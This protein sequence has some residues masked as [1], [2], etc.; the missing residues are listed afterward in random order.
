[1]RAR[2]RLRQRSSF[3]FRI[4]LVLLTAF[5][6]AGEKLARPAPSALDEMALAYTMSGGDPADLCAY[7]GDEQHKSACSLCHLVSHARLP[8]AGL[9]LIQAERL[10]LA[11]VVLPDLLR[12]VAQSR[13]PTRSQRGPPFSFS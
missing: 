12:S 11:R 13:D 2:L 10:F 3:I 5:S 8:T 6:L 9:T 1:M 7:D 4:A